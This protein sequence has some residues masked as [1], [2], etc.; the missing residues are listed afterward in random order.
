MTQLQQYGPKRMD[1]ATDLETYKSELKRYLKNVAPVFAKAAIGDFSEDV[2]LPE[3]ENELTV[4]FVGVQIMVDAIRQKEEES[5][6][7][8]ARL[9]F[10]NQEAEKEKASYH[11][12]LSSIAEGLITVD[13]ESRITLINQVAAD[14][15]GLDPKAVINCNYY[16]IVIT[17]D[18]DGKPVPVEQRPLMQAAQTGKQQLR[19]LSDGLEYVRSDGTTIP[20]S[21][22]ASP[23]KVGTKVIGAVSTFRDIS[24]EKQLDR[25]KSEIISIASHQ[26]RT[27]LTAIKW[28]SETLITPNSTMPVAKRTKYLRQIH[29][30]NERMIA[31]VNDLLNVSRIELGTMGLRTKPIDLP[32]MLEEVLKDLAQIIKRK[33]IKLQKKIGPE[34]DAVVTD[35]RH[36]QVILQNLLSNAVKYARDKKRVIITIEKRENDLYIAIKDEGYGIPSAQQS[37]IFGKLFRADNAQKIVSEGSGLGLYVCK[38]MVGQLGGQILFESVENEGTTFYVTLPLTAAAGQVISS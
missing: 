31:L 29:A 13:K 15:L 24:E 22:T 21:I 23:V 3:E 6:S 8:L 9:N 35:P 27:P 1:R 11:A 37:K 10:A 25:T 4:F 19:D 26:L 17:K 12:T 16:D 18:R 20:V 14:M 36:M 33:Q 32:L 5:Q 2:Q 30:S 28:V 34:L 38:A 7:A